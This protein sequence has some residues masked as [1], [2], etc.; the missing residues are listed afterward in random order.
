MNARTLIGLV[1]EQYQLQDPEQRRIVRP[2]TITSSGQVLDLDETIENESEEE[3]FELWKNP[4]Q[5]VVGVITV[6]SNC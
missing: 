4:V 2:A 3:V 5:I 1:A 6:S